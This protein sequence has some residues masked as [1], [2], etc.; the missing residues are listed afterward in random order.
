MYK[1]T[2]IFDFIA[3][4]SSDEKKNETKFKPLASINFPNFSGIIN[5]F[6]KAPRSDDIELGNG[7]GGKAGLA[8]METLD[9]STKDPWNQENGGDAVDAEKP[10]EGEKETAEEQPKEKKQSLIASIQSYNCSIGEFDRLWWSRANVV[11]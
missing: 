7:P 9:D 10:K 4:D 3:A 1:Q 8:S 11:I 5:K 2:T 6:R